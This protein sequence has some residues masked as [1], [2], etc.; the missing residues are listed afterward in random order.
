MPPDPGSEVLSLILTPSEPT[1]AGEDA[2]PLTPE[3]GEAAPLAA[4]EGDEDR[5][6]LDQTEAILL[7]LA[8][9]S[10]AAGGLIAYE[11]RRR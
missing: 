5:R 11:Y 7:W 1:Y 4:A 6:G 3:G 8:T 10:L 2:A 9:M